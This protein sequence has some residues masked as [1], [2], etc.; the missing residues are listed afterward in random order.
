ML[1]NANTYR[2]SI[3]GF[4][5]VLEDKS[6]AEK[7]SPVEG[8]VGVGTGSLSEESKQYPPRS[9]KKVRPKKCVGLFLIFF[10]SFGGS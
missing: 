7:H 6:T 2:D 1:S 4:L 8:T 5:G 3:L 9:E 10:K